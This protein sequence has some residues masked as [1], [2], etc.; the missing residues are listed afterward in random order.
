MPELWVER[1]APR[2]LS[3]IVGQPQAIQEMRR[4]AEGWKLGKPEKPA[5]LL[6]GAAGTGK[7]AAATALAHEF[8]WDLIELNASDERSSQEIER[9]AGTA[10]TCGT[11]QGGVGGKRLIVLDEADNVYEAADR[12]GYSAIRN[13]L[14]QTRNPVVLIANDQYAIPREIREDCISVNFRRL[15][16]QIIAGVLGRICRAEGIEAEP[17]VLRVI[18]ETANGDMRSAINDLQ[19]LAMGRKRLAVED[20]SLYRRD[21]GANVFDVLRQLVHTRDVKRA[22]ELLLTLDR[23]PGDALAWIS[24]NIPRMLMKPGD[25]AGVYEAISRAD[26]FLGRALRRQAYRLWGFA[27][28]LMS[29]GV[30]LSR[31][32]ELKFVRFQYPSSGIYFARSRGTRALIDGIAKKIAAKCHTSSR[33]ARK[34]FLPY[35]NMIFKHDR[36]SASRIAAEL[37]LSE[38]EVKHLSSVG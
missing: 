38:A 20:L 18:A 9:I 21:R 8:G 31:E 25:L 3:D 23:E 6:Y 16:P 13:L 27:S 5:L 22:R 28:D 4:W 19:T 32:G 29:A 7:T 26:V 37:E 2:R 36:K 33:T 14:A 34:D 10:S 11:I 15:T 12:G 35:L 30:A 24:E 1:Y 17:T